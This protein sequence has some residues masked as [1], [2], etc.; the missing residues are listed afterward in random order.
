MRC[1]SSASQRGAHT[2]S[3]SHELTPHMGNHSNKPPITWCYKRTHYLLMSTY[4][5]WISAT[6]MIWDRA[7]V[8]IQSLP[9]FFF[10]L[11]KNRTERCLLVKEAKEIWHWHQSRKQSTDTNAS[12]AGQLCVP[13]ITCYKLPPISGQSPKA[14]DTHMMKHASVYRWTKEPEK[15]VNNVH[16]FKNT[17][18]GTG[19]LNLLLLFQKCVWQII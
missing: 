10:W 17:S 6:D 13:S 7:L 3:P 4:E 19:I 8:L 1:G 11:G 12:H 14:P 15:R 16:L 9:T 18:F 5:S 2:T